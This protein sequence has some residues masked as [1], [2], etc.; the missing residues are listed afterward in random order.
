MRYSFMTICC[1]G[2]KEKFRH[3]KYLPEPATPFVC[4]SCKYNQDKGIKVRRWPKEMLEALATAAL[5]SEDM[6]RKAQL[7]IP[8]SE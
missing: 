6:P 3:A 7:L 4:F 8:E 2:C 1:V 5:N